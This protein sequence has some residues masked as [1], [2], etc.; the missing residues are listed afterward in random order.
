ML[1]A[2]GPTVWPI[3]AASFVLVLVVLERFYSLRKRRVVPGPFIDCY[4]SQIA[5]G[6]LERGSALDLCDEN[7]SPM[8]EVFAAGTKKWGKPAVEVEQAVLDEGE[9]VAAQL[10]RYLRVI[11]GVSQIT[12]LLGL[13]GTV[14]GMIEAFNAISANDAMGKSALLAGG[15]SSALLS[16]AAGLIVAIPAMTLYLYFAG[17]VEMLVSEIDYYGQQLVSLISAEGLQDRRSQ[18]RKKAA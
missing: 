16:T 4:L 7:P 17:R 5:E 11:S 15:I 1:L 10:R 14:W 9:R 8:A 12:P 6:A 13:L 2:G 3:M 18:P